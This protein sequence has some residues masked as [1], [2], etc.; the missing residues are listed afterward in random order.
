MKKET[1]RVL[2]IA[3]HA[4]RVLEQCDIR[5]H[6]AG[7]IVMRLRALIKQTEKIVIA[8]AQETTK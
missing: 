6:D 4:L 7:R 2:E 1:R 8:K 5:P 3:T